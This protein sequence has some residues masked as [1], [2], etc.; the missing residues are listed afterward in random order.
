MLPCIQRSVI[1]MIVMIMT[2]IFPE[3][4]EVLYILIIVMIM[5]VMI[6]EFIEVLY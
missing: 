1:Q 4:S 6:P 3:Y 2:V 5:S